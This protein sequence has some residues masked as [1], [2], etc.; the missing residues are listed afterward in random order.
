[1]KA[2]SSRASAKAIRRRRLAVQRLKAEQPSLSVRE[3]AQRLGVPK[4]TVERDLKAERPMVNPPPAGAAE[5]GN[6]RAVK[7]GAFSERLLASLR[8]EAEKYAQLTWPHLSDTDV[9]LYARMAARVQLLGEYELEHGVVKDLVRGEI[10]ATSTQLGQFEGRLDRLVRRFDE[11]APRG[12]PAG[13]EPPWRGPR[14][15]EDD[16]VC[17]A[18][19]S[20]LAG[21]TREEVLADEEA[22]ARA[23]ALWRRSAPIDGTATAPASGRGPAWQSQV[24]RDELDAGPRRRELPPGA[25]PASIDRLPED[26]E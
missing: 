24:R 20:S 16:P 18:L 13:T 8:Q 25:P 7:S 4:S 2:K 10:F 19:F 1:M 15:D 21:L 6:T 17:A 26:L 23:R 14:G 22:S 9:A 5:S 3:I 11:A 12:A